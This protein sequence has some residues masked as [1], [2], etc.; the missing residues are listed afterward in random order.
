MTKLVP[1]H[2]RPLIEYINLYEAR[3]PV[4][5][6]QAPD[7]L[8]FNKSGYPEKLKSSLRDIFEVGGGIIVI[9]ERFHDL[10][11]GFDLGPT[12]LIEVPVFEYDQQRQ[13]PGRF[14]ILHIVAQKTEFVPEASENVEMYPSGDAWKPD[15]WMRGDDVIAVRAS[16]AEGPDL[17]VDPTLSNRI[18]VSDR[19]YRAIKAEKIT[20]RSLKF[21]P[22]RV[23]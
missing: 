12:R 21:K 6:E 7:Y 14:W 18:F 10:L 17:W 19:L 23:V 15:P 22:C 13:R 5:P 8:H 11:Q 2:D 3:V 1:H 9:S 4:T 20:A 16:A